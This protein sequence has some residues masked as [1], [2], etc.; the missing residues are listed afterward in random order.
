[1]VKFGSIKSTTD[2]DDK[3]STLSTIPLYHE[4]SVVKTF[5]QFEIKARVRNSQEETT[6]YLIWADKVKELKLKDTLVVNVEKYQ[7]FFRVEYPINT[8]DGA[9]FIIKSWTEKV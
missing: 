4:G 5:K 7:P 6:E 2:L 9:Y 3:G 8:G 1:M